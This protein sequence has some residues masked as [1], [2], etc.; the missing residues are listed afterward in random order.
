MT[1]EGVRASYADFLQRLSE[2]LLGPRGKLAAAVRRDILE[3]RILEGA[4]NA[5]V[6]RVRAN[7]PTVTQAHIDE[8]RANG[9][10]EDEIFD[11]AV[12][13]AFYAGAERFQAVVSALK[14]AG[15]AP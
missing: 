13:A 15:D 5:F 12:C 9:M 4:L 1:M 8:L 3:G 14:E 2:Q 11:A 10:D 6:V 7:A